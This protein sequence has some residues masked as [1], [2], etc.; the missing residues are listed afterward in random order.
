VSLTLIFKGG[1]KKLAD[2][3][4]GLPDYK[5]VSVDV[6]VEKSRFGTLGLRTTVDLTESGYDPTSSLC[7]L[8]KLFKIA[9]GSGAWIDLEIGPDGQTERINGLAKMYQYLIANPAVADYVRGR[10]LAVANQT[11]GAEEAPEVED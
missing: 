3:L 4:K 2:D 1:G 7:R 9:Q 11:K 6:E 10:V 5:G 8:A